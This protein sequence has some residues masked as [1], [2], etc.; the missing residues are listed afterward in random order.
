MAVIAKY[1]ADGLTPGATVDTTLAGPGDT[2]WGSVTGTPPT[3]VSGQGIRDP[4]IAFNQGAGS[5][6]YISWGSGKL[7]GNINVWGLRMYVKLS[8][9]AASGWTLFSAYLDTPMAL[10]I[11]V[12]GAGGVTGQ[13]RIRD[14]DNVQHGSTPI[15]LQTD[16]V[17][18]VEILFGA[19][20]V[21]INVY[22]GD[23]RALYTTAN[24]NNAA[25]PVPIT[26]VNKMSFGPPDS[27]PTVPTF[28]LDD[29]QLINTATESGPAAVSTEPTLSL[30]TGTDE[31]YIIGTP[32]A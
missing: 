24:T 18:R 27:T 19:G 26:S 17:Y 31:I 4:Q 7:G 10:K 11:T 25:G 32:P 2:S 12:A 1:S 21:T 6:S 3:I 8:G 29:I 22:E 28:Y 16:T 13:L 23:G 30:W 14:G 15:G 9:V 5:P 20:A